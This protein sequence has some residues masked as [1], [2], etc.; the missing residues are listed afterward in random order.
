MFSSLNVFFPNIFSVNCLIHSKAEEQL[1]KSSL[2]LQMLEI[3]DSCTLKF[4]T[5]TTQPDRTLVSCFPHGGPGWFC[6]PPHVN[7]EH[8]SGSVPLVT[9]L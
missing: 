7:Q 6:N 2:S 4:D 3:T 5:G 1:K 8:L 9:F